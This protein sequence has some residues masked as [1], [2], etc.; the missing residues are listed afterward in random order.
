LELEGLRAFA[1]APA[2]AAADA[3]KEPPHLVTLARTARS[4]GTLRL[5]LLLTRF[6]WE[7]TK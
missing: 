3:M 2:V 5:K 7:M 1:H 4:V 6:K